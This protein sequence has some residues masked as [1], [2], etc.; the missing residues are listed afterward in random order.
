MKKQK[1]TRE[2]R[3][4]PQIVVFAC[5]WCSYAGADTA[6]VSRI[7]Y[8]P[9]IRVIRMMCSGRI[10]P[11]F[12]FK[13][14][15]KGADGVLITGCHIGDCH[16][17]SGNE[18]AIE[19]FE[20]ITKLVDLMGIDRQRIGLEWISAAEG[21]R[22]GQV[23]DD[24]VERVA[25]LGPLPK[26]APRE[27]TRE[28]TADLQN[29]VRKLGALSCYECGKCTGVC[30]VAR[31][32]EGFSPRRTVRKALLSK[33]SFEAARACLTCGLCDAR[34]PQSV[35]IASLIAAVREAD[36]QLEGWGDRPH[37]G[38]FQALGRMMSAPELS[39]ARGGWLPE[40][41]RIDRNSDTLLYV[42]CAPYYDAFFSDL[43]ANTLDA[44]R[45]AVKI[46]NRLGTEPT[47]LDNERCCGH[48][49]Y[50][51]GD[52]QTF[53]EL[54]LLNKAQIEQL[55]AQR[56]VFTCPECLSTFKQL[57]PKV[58]VELKAELLSM[59]QLIAQNARDLELASREEVV[60]FQDPCRMARHLADTVSP[61]GAL[62]AI[63][64]ISLHEMAHM[65]TNAICC[66]GS[67]GCCDATTKTIQVNRIEEARKTG[68]GLLV[69]ACPKCEI[70]LRCTVKGIGEEE[71]ALRDLTGLVAE[72]LSD[73]P[74]MST[75][76]SKRTAD[77]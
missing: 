42:G 30:P 75:V 17:V 70:H 39:P 36:F 15:E 52:R 64:G 5:N 34:C 43:D 37:G 33:E 47:V 57:Y 41:A 12:V 18:R 45:G 7:Q 13:A 48:D 66:A 4:I 19:I 51:G 31:V 32:R 27:G 22:F 67:W 25:K 20:I 59:P 10:H 28:L 76:S 55:G 38:I 50:W 11:A 54:A 58:G 60:T 23:M 40:D 9:H 1:Q 35:E 77:D 29:R 14:F 56:I 8:T 73:E 6:G 62:T 74:A 21:P 71:F 61:R 72:C 24:F 49:F 2:K 26:I 46:L 53:R 3:F 63:P 16:Y 44:A 68:A 69:T 65:G